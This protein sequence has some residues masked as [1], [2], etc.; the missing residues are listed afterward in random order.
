MG[1]RFMSNVEGKTRSSRNDHSSSDERIEF[2]PGLTARRLWSVVAAP[3][4]IPRDA[5]IPLHRCTYMWR[6]HQ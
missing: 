3:T 4:T 5:F 6:A 1:Q 2:H